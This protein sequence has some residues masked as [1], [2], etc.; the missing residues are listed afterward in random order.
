[1]KKPKKIVLNAGA[2]DE[3]YLGSEPKWDS[4]IKPTQADILRAYNWY[5]SIVDEAN[6]QKI[7]L[8]YLT[9]KQEIEAIKAIEAWAIP[10]YLISLIRM[11]ENGY[12]LSNEEEAKIDGKISELVRRGKEKLKSIKQSSPSIS[13]QKRAEISAGTYI[14][15]IEA[16]LDK[17]YRNKY[18]TNFKC[19]EWLSQRQVKPM[20]SQCIADYYKPL[21]EEVVLALSKKDAVCTQG[22]SKHT[23]SGM[24]RYVSF[25]EEL[26]ADCERWASNIKKQVVRKPRKKKEI[27]AEQLVKKLKYQTAMPELKLVSIDPSKL[28]GAKEAWLYN[29]KTRML[30][31]YVAVDRGGIKTKGTTLQNFDENKSSM[32]KVRNPET[33]SEYVDGGPKAIIKQFD[34]LKVKPM[35]CNGR[36]NETTL[37]LRI[38]K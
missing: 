20:I 17:F 9:S 31:H 36:V 32:K 18:T 29:S 11:S 12:K 26:I 7:L 8:A 14:A 25:L 24:I 3:R 27:P 22:Y 2:F 4:K 13:V 28:I 30:Q 6:K 21:L 34:S 10:N 19:Y 5:N 33:V 38:I 16:E 35:K 37:I 1:M 23:K 15:E